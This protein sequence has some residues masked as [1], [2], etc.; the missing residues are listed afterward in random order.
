VRQ[1]EK[2]DRER[3]E[4]EKKLAEKIKAEKEQAEKPK[5]EVK[6]EEPKKE[7]LKKEEPKKEESAPKR[8]FKRSEKTV[9]PTSPGS[10]PDTVSNWRDKSAPRLNPF[11]RKQQQETRKDQENR[12]DQWPPRGWTSK[13]VFLKEEKVEIKSKNAFECL[14]TE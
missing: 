3:Q 7:E 8:E 12:K 10:I 6:K 4:R 9:T 14:N 1:K 5:E 2:E 11:E 13:P